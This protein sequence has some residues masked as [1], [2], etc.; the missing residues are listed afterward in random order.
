M[1]PPYVKIT[2]ECQAH[3]RFQVERKPN[4][5]HPDS[6]S[7]R[8]GLYDAVKC[9]KCPYWGTIIE[10]A[11]ITVAPVAAATDTTGILPGLEG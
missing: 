10:Q 7:P 11:I 6:S 5:R 9:P 2:A 1:K 4:K 8:D 3:G